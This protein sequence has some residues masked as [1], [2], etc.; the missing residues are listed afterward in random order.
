MMA[1]MWTVLAVG[2]TPCFEVR[3]AGL[4]AVNGIYQAYELPY[5]AGPTAFRRGDFWPFR[6]HQVHRFCARTASRAHCTPTT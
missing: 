4:Q 2:G 6:W 5:Y 1:S 3:G